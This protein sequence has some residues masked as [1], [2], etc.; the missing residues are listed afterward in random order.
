MNPRHLSQIL[1]PSV[2]AA[3][4][5]FGVAWLPA[6]TSSAT[7]RQEEAE[8]ERLQLIEELVAA[9]SLP[10]EADEFDRRIA[11]AAVAVPDTVDL[12]V[13]VRAAGDAAARSGVFVE[14]IAPLTVSSDSDP[15]AI[16]RLPPGTSSVT[17]SIGARGSY[18]RLLAFVDELVALDRLVVIDL[19]DLNADEGESDEVVM[20]L[21]LRIFTTSQLVQT[22][23]FDDDFFDDGYIDDHDMTEDTR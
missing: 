4:L 19:V 9:R 6:A 23:S 7:D 3:A 14:Q 5:W 17:I 20:D 10:D 21:E 15:E 22:L 16:D 1:G 13:F 12:A 8:F 11:A 2:L 18:E